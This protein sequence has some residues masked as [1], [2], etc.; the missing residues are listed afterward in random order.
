V[1]PWDIVVIVLVLGLCGGLTWR[2][3]AVPIGPVT[4]HVKA[5]DGDWYYPLDKA[6]QFEVSG[7]LGNTRI[8]IAGDA[9][10][11][12]DSPCPNKT[13]VHSGSVNAAGGWIA[14]LPNRVLI[15]V[16]GRPEAAYDAESH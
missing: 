5:A 8:G 1:K 12:L 3:Y 14:C 15:T 10:R 16:E 13:C 7:P 11:I 4:V 6:R 2:I 9:A